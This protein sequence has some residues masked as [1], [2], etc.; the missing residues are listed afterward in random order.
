MHTRQPHLPRLVKAST[1]RPSNTGRLLS[2]VEHQVAEMHPLLLRLDAQPWFV[3]VLVHEIA[4]EV[5]DT[6]ELDGVAVVDDTMEPGEEVLG[7]MFLVQ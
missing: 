2:C 4:A 6:S 7:E 3:T 1:P 5:D